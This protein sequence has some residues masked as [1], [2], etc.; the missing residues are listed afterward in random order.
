MNMTEAVKSVLSNYANF[1]GRAIRSEYWW[2]TLANVIGSVILNGI[3]MA[4]GVPILSLIW[5]LALLVPGLAVG[6]RRLHDLD[7]SGWW[8][9]IVLV[10]VVGVILLI[11][12]FATRG[13]VGPNRFGPDPLPN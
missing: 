9:L 11:Y 10:P 1:S 3:D 2:F 12:W 8:L 6:V 7:R 13:T 4:T 5:A